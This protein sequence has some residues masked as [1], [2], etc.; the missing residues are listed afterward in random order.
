L[1]PLVVFTL[2]VTGVPLGT[3]AGLTGLIALIIWLVEGPFHR[4]SKGVYSLSWDDK[5]GYRI[6]ET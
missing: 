3:F 4:L 5:P 6:H 2:L 1:H